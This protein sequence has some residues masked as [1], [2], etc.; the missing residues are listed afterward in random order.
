MGSAFELFSLI[1]FPARVVGR[2]LLASRYAASGFSAIK[3]T[4]NYGDRRFGKSLK[5]RPWLMID[6][7]ELEIIEDLINLG[8]DAQLEA[9]RISQLSVCG[10]IAIIVR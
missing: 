9:W 4:S 1:G 7:K 3:P 2:A 6:V 8:T 10:M 5:W